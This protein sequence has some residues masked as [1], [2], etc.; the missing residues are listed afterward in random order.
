[1]VFSTDKDDLE[2]KKTDE[3]VM[4]MNIPYLF[5]LFYLGTS[6]IQHNNIIFQ[7][8][9]DIREFGC[10]LPSLIHR[11]NISIDPITLEVIIMHLIRYMNIPHLL[12]LI[13]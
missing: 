10:V 4:F 3:K 7:I 6:I 5:Y 11:R 9:V 1:M 13:K 12:I 2:F 8:I